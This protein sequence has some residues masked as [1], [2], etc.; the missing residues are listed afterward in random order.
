[1]L[2]AQAS[3]LNRQ[4]AF[5]QR[6]RVGRAVERANHFCLGGQGTGDKGMVGAV[7][8]LPC[9]EPEAIYYENVYYDELLM[10]RHVSQ[11]YGA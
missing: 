8:V 2:R 10:C 9:L 7:D 4:R 5:Q 11:S 6:Q 1:M 3:L